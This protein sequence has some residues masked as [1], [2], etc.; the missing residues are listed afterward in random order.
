MED[1]IHTHPLLQEP[2]HIPYSKVLVLV[3]VL[4]KENHIGPGSSSSRGTLE[5]ELELEGTALLNMVIPSHQM[6]IG[7]QG[8]FRL[9]MVREKESP[10]LLAGLIPVPVMGMVASSREDGVDENKGTNN[11]SP[12]TSAFGVVS[13]QGVGTTAVPVVVSLLES[14][15]QTTP[16]YGSQA[17][18]HHV[19]NCSNQRHL[20]RQEQPELDEYENHAT[21]RPSNAKNANAATN[22]SA[23]EGV[24]LALVAND[25]EDSDVQEQEG[26]HELSNESSVE[27]PL[28]QLSRVEER[29]GWW[30]MVVLVRSTSFLHLFGHS[31][32]YNYG[33]S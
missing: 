4:V 25:G 7:I 5:L 33:D 10:K 29:G 17:L 15:H 2:S 28:P 13:R 26:G 24:G 14:L 32:Y 1:H 16:T 19:Q 27:G 8:I 12:Q 21:E 3:L 30:V 31:Q 23:V 18:R 20:P 11:L 6:D 22:I 9:H